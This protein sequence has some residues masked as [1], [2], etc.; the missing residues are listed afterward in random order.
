MKNIL[1]VCLGALVLVS[2]S[3]YAKEAQNLQIFSVDNAKGLLNAKSIEKAFNDSGLVVDVNN[4]MNSIFSKRYGKVH[5]KNY[6][7]AIFTNPTLV[8]KLMKKHMK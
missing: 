8:S 2:T 5:H 7:L 1:K 3:I 4:D 6:N